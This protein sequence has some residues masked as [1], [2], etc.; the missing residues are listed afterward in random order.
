[1]KL[2]ELWS[3][4]KRATS[5]LKPEKRPIENED[6]YAVIQRATQDRHK[7]KYS[8]GIRSYPGHNNR[9]MTAGRFVQY[10]NVGEGGR[11][12]PIYHAAR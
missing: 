3:W 11:T 4:L 2:K 8:D 10:I 6:P 12:K 7:R 1:M 5:S 9:R